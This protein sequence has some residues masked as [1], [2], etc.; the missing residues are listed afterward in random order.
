MQCIMCNEFLPFVTFYCRA[1]HLLSYCSCNFLFLNKPSCAILG[2]NLIKLG[3]T[4]I[5]HLTYSNN[6]R[7]PMNTIVC[8]EFHEKE[9]PEQ[10]QLWSFCMKCLNRCTW[11]GRRHWRRMR[12]KQPPLRVMCFRRIRGTKWTTLQVSWETHARYEKYESKW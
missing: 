5:G 9:L 2:D 1:Q 10:A 12:R 8:W 4:T 11:K 6:L 7:G 3:L